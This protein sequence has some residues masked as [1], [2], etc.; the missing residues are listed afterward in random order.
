LCVGLV[1]PSRGGVGGGNGETVGTLPN[2]SG[3][4]TL[5]ISRAANDSAPAMYLE[6]SMQAIYDA[7]VGLSGRS[8]VT[9]E[10][11]DAANQIVRV[12]FHGDLRLELDRQAFEQGS[13]KVGWSVPQAYGPARVTMVLG[14]RALASGVVSGR[15]LGLPVQELESAGG[16][17]LA[18]LQIV[19]SGRGTHATLQIFSSEDRLILAQTH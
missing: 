6:G 7:V 10:S 8:V 1:V 5:D 15:S 17:D 9:A 13:L 11:I 12:T 18:P 3:G 19:T 4:S 2:T 16:L 14:E